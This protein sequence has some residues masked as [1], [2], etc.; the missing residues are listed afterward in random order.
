M[1]KY[2]AMTQNAF[3]KLYFYMDQL[4]CY[5]AGEWEDAK[6]GVVTEPEILEQWDGDE[7]QKC[8]LVRGRMV[9]TQPI[10]WE[11][12]DMFQA[13]DIIVFSNFTL[14]WFI[15]GERRG[16]WAEIVGEGLQPVEMNHKQ[17][18]DRDKKR[19]RKIFG[20]LKGR[21]VEEHGV[22]SED[23]CLESIIRNFTEKT[24]DAADCVEVYDDV[25]FQVSYP[26]WYR[27]WCQN[28]VV[29]SEGNSKK[30]RLSSM[31]DGMYRSRHYTIQ[32]ILKEMD[33]L[34]ITA[35]TDSG[36]V[37]DGISE[38]ERKYLSTKKLPNGGLLVMFKA[39]TFSYGHLQN[40]KLTDLVCS[41]LGNWLYRMG[42]PNKYRGRFD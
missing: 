10:D 13:D 1:S 30:W 35:G 33:R 39:E 28:Y 4:L 8:A 17:G 24:L 21:L 32:K 25:V 22:C 36:D 7:G 6:E 2:Y 40:K 12:W 5:A 14:Q 31:V 37:V 38:E 23:K 34:G 42:E 11:H 20:L 26:G 41:D 29:D 18:E 3:G 19:E 16:Y 9:E 15:G 27:D